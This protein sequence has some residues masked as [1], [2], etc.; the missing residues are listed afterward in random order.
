M[1]HSISVPPI[2]ILR[3]RAT[4]DHSSDCQRQTV[5]CIQ[6]AER[7]STAPSSAV[8]RQL[9]DRRLSGATRDPTMGRGRLSIAPAINCKAQTVLSTKI[10]RSRYAL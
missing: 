3:L 10:N 6:I 7:L 4:D 1:A 2:K 9:L 5:G 8:R